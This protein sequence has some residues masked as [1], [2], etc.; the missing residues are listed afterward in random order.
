MSKTRFVPHLPD[1]IQPDEYEGDPEGRLVRF[2]I[3]TTEDGIV[4]LGDA[5]R[6]IPL[7]KMLH[8]LGADSIEQ[9][10]CG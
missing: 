3:T 7:E 5:M 8:R 1:L 10:L 6:S 9:M 4:I 2:Q